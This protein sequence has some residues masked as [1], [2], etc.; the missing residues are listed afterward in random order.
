MGA[1]ALLLRG[2]AAP[3]PPIPHQNKNRRINLVDRNKK[4]W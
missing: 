1:E 3:N 2:D 4:L